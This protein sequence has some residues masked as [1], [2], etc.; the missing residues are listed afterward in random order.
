[1]ENRVSEMGQDRLQDNGRGGRGSPTRRPASE[2]QHPP[3]Q[4]SCKVGE[5]QPAPSSSQQCIQVHSPLG[6]A[7]GFQAAGLRTVLSAKALADV[8]ELRE[9][10]PGAMSENQAANSP[11]RLASLV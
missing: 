11:T 6:S 2:R 9:R 7:P 8:T 10:R 3:P 4:P 5:V 1:M